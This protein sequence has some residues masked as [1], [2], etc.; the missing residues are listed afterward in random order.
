MK[1]GQY[2]A[3]VCERI[4]AREA[5]RLSNHVVKMQ[6][7]PGTL[8]LTPHSFN[9]VDYLTGSPA[10]RDDILED[11]AQLLAAEA[12][13]FQET[14]GS[15]S[16]GHNCAERLVQL[17]CERP[18]HF[19]HNRDAA[20]VR[21]FFAVLACFRFGLLALCDVNARTDVPEERAIGGKARR[22]NI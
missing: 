17:V 14:E 20:E 7:L 1:P 19:S 2:C 16:V 4:G 9:S 12:I 15:P 10:I 11:F 22:A 13:A 5:E 8:L 3:M 6:E 21:D 18:G